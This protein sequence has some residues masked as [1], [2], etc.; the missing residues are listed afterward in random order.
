M[1]IFW[2]VDLGLVANLARIWASA[3]S[4]SVSYSYFYGYTSQCYYKRGGLEG[5]GLVVGRGLEKRDT[6]VGMYYGALAAGAVFGAV[7]L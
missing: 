4:C 7:Q 1:L 2:V 6:T 3:S 5:R